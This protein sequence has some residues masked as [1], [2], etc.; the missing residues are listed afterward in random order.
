MPIRVTV[1][2]NGSVVSGEFIPERGNSATP[3]KRGTSSKTTM[4]TT[5]PWSEDKSRKRKPP[6][7]KTK[8]KRPSSEPFKPKNTKKSIPKVACPVCR[9]MVGKPSLDR[10]VQN[11]HPAWGGLSLSFLESCSRL[12][13]IKE[14]SWVV[15]SDCG[16]EVKER[17]LEKH[18]RKVH[19]ARNKRKPMNFSKPSQARDKG[20]SS[21]QHGRSTF[22][23]KASEQPGRQY[24][25]EQFEETRYG[26]KY[27]GQVR[28]ELNGRFGSLP[29][30][31][32]YGEESGPS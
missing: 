22:D 15:C 2:A 4:K 1:D 6:W 5:F 14:E 12:F 24:L 21:G 20:K 18:V 11:V 16:S 9:T 17:N 31:D 13:P 26:D 7:I 30:Y 25:R 27:L 8:T 10:H 3:P 28:R 19:S 23:T 29:L 32:D